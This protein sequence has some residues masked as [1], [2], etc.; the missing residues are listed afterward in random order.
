MSGKFA[1]LEEKVEAVLAQL[2]ELRRERTAIREENRD[3]GSELNRMRQSFEEFKLSQA[4][5]ADVV[6]SKLMAVLDR[7]KEFETI[8]L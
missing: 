3:L 1:L 4:D 2:E 5:Q 7:I 6:K 8:G